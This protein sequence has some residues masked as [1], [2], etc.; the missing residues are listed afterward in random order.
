MD[1]AGLK[2]D[3]PDVDEASLKMQE[4][5]MLDERLNIAEIQ[6]IAPSQVL[7]LTEGEAP[8]IADLYDTV[9]RNWVAPLPTGVPIRVRQHKERLARRFATELILASSRLRNFEPQEP[10]TESQ[11][12]ASQ[13]SGV[14]LPILP[15]KLKENTLDE[16]AQWPFS[17]PLP[18]LPHSS[19]PS[20]SM[21]PSSPLSSPFG[22]P[23]SADP[24]ARLSKHLQIR[25]NSVTPTVVPSNVNYLLAHWKPGADPHTYDWAATEE[26]LRPENDDEITQKQHEKDRRRR[27]RRLKRQQREDELMR[28]NAS[29]QPVIWMQNQ[30]R[31]P[32]GG[33]TSSS[34][35]PSQAH[36]QVPVPVPSFRG[37]GGMDILAPM[38]QVEPGRFG[39]RPDLKKKKKNRVSGF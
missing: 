2:I 29:S 24:I 22:P 28:V 6:R 26:A 3:V 5:S 27:E 21:P 37:P 30:N 18:P 1:F 10:A 25:D 7:C 38:S 19:I 14:A 31:L 33:L 8:T 32:P 13:Y 23:A 17:Q 12:G 20:S 9:L 36:S 4:L 15:S 16:A 11:R 35:T 34:R 39:G